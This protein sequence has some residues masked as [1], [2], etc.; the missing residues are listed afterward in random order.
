MVQKIS[1][2]KHSTTKSIRFEVI[3]FCLRILFTSQV[4]SRHVMRRVSLAARRLATRAYGST[5]TSA[6]SGSRRVID[7]D[8]HFQQFPRRENN[9]YVRVADQDALRD[10]L[11]RF[12]ARSHSS[13]VFSQFFGFLAI[14]LVF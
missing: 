6:M 9:G 2:F 8:P 1:R 14:F 3:S 13:M 4:K 7:N 11:D 10:V 5:A 12:E